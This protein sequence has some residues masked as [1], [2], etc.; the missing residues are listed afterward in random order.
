MSS[1][2]IVLTKYAC[3]LEGHDLNKY[4]AFCVDPACK[5]KNKFVCQEC[6]F[7]LHLQH[8]II[9]LKNIENDINQELKKFALSQ[10][11]KKEMEKR[12]ETQEDNFKESSETLK[13][14]VLQAIETRIK[15]FTEVLKQKLTEN[16][17]LFINEDLVPI[18]NFKNISPTTESDFKELSDFLLDYT[19]KRT[20]ENKDIFASHPP[21]QIPKQNFKGIL[22]VAKKN[23][24]SIEESVSREMKD[25]EKKILEF[26]QNTFLNESKMFGI[27][28][29]EWSQLKF[30]AYEFYYSLENKNKTIKKKTADGTITIAVAKTPLS[31][32]K[33]YLVEFEVFLQ[34]SGDMDIGFGRIEVGPSCWLR[35]QGSYSITNMGIFEQGRAT[36]KEIRLY[37]GCKVTFKIYLSS[38]TKKKCH[39]QI[40][41]GQSYECPIEIEEELYI[42]CGIRRVGN[43]IVV[44]EFSLIE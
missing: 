37:N 40:A 32:G 22:E 20:N 41:G 39:I 7:S 38:L 1:P 14:R 12:I 30:G 3:N 4:F 34:N 29:F 31:V 28:A 44:K 11:E 5:V 35:V 42:M 10:G 27:V 24:L 25:E 19:S 15:D 6:L 13:D 36:Q 23:L 21:Q 8:K 43:A 33:N 17:E 9:K 18:L 16:F 2:Q 26:I